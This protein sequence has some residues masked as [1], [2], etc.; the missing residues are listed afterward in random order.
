VAQIERVIMYVANDTCAC[1]TLDAEISAY[2]SG[3][4]TLTDVLSD[5]EEVEEP[6]DYSADFYTFDPYI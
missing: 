6:A 3:N 4:L 2:L 1:D 5:T